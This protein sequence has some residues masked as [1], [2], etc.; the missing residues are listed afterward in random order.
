MLLADAAIQR[1]ML[2]MRM[3]IDQ[4]GHDEAGAAV[5]RAVGRSGEAGP[6]EG[7]PVVGESD[8]DIAAIDMP[9]QP[10][11]PGDHPGGVFD[12][13]RRHRFR[14]PQHRCCHAIGILKWSEEW[15]RPVHAT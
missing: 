11:V 1:L 6:D 10:F 9:A 2:G 8:I 7:D 15:P 12:Q 14:S 3:D 4:P 13:R 5:D